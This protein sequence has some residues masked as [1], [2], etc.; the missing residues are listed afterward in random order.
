M[1][2]VFGAF[3]YLTLRLLR[4]SWPSVGYVGKPLY[5]RGVKRLKLGR[6]VRIFPGSR[7]EVEPAAELII[8]D[9][10]SIGQR[11]HIY[12]GKKITIGSG[13]LLAENVFISD[14]D[15]TWFMPEVPIHQQPDKQSETVIG[16]NCFLGYGCVILA[17][18]KLGEGVIVGAN[19]VVRGVYA[20]GSVV[21]GSPAKIIKMR[22]GYSA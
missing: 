18:T 22:H 7:M 21:A 19:S 8:G 1:F 5:L 14:V 11:A 9:N 12:A 6:N 3:R 20:S 17:G 15:H 16:N 2:R 10:I 4:C 13:C